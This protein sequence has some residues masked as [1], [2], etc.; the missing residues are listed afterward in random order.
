[1]KTMNGVRTES[2]AALFSTP[3]NLMKKQLNPLPNGPDCDD[4]NVPG[5]TALTAL[6]PDWM[7]G[8]LLE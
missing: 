5:V 4:G 6:P 3:W 1:M 7:P 8:V 2:H